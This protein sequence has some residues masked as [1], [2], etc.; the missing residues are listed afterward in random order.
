MTKKKDGKLKKKEKQKKNHMQYHY[1]VNAIQKNSA[2]I[3]SN[4]EES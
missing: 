3:A 2:L 1:E 4:T